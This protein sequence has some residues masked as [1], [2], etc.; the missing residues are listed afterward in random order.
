M[1][2]KSEVSNPSKSE[3]EKVESLKSVQFRPHP[4]FRH[5]SA[6]RRW[7]DMTIKT[8]SGNINQIMTKTGTIWNTRLDCGTSRSSKQMKKKGGI[9]IN[10]L[11]NEFVQGLSNSL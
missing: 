7:T 9:R 1:T 5:L 10:S 3:S 4:R 11:W 2:Y 8:K 6:D